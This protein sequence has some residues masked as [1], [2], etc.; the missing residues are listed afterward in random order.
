V[1]KE[2]FDTK[3]FGH[4]Y[5]PSE[6][7]RFLIDLADPRP[8]EKVV[9][10]G[11]NPEVIQ[12]AV[13]TKMGSRAQQISSRPKPEELEN[14]EA[15]Y[16]VV[17]CAPTFG[18]SLNTETGEP[19]EE[20]WLKWGIGHLSPN[21]RL[22]II[23]PTGLLSNYS[24]QP[25]R[26]FLL[27]ESC[28][29]AVL[30]LPAGW[31]QGTATQASILFITTLEGVQEERVV[32]M[33]R[34]GKPETI[35]W[36]DLTSQVLAEAPHLSEESFG[37]VY[38]VPAV[39]LEDSRLDAQYYD[40]KY[41]EIHE[42]DLEKFRAIELADLVVIRS[43][44]R[45]SKED[46]SSYGIPF[47]QV[48]N[49]VSNGGLNLEN[50]KRIKPGV[51]RDSRG[52]SQPGE[53]LMT[54]AGTVGKVAFLGSQAPADGVCIDTSLRR[55]HA[56]DQNRVLPEYL[57]LYLRSRHAQLHIERSLSGSVIR[58]L[59]NP[60]LGKMIVYL[61][62]I[63]DQHEIVS[64]FYKLVEQRDAQLL[65]VFPDIE[66]MQVVTQPPESIQAEGAEQI[67]LPLTMAEPPS[68]LEVVQAEFPFPIARAYTSF[69]GMSNQSQSNR[70]KALIDT[71]ETVVYYLYGMV[72]ADQLRRLK[73][74]DADLKSEISYSIAGYSMEKRLKVI[75]HVIKLAKDNPDVNLFVPEL[76]EFEVRVCSEIHN[77]LRNKY[78]H[79]STPPEPWCERAVNRFEPRLE[80]LLQSLTP[81]KD[82]KLMQVT[83]LAVR[84]DRFHHNI[85]SMMG[86]NPLFQSQVEELEN[87]LPADTQHVILIDQDY[88]VLDLYPLFLFYAWESTGMQYHLCFLKQVVGEAPNKRLKVESTHGVG[89]ALTETDLGLDSLLST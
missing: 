14:L 72:V 57:A 15:K 3:Q 20:F 18:L 88:N 77:Q 35:P 46:F 6:V 69:K 5:A 75:F 40:P 22:A 11:L 81:L 25:I 38:V 66:Q 87:P 19:C 27:E 41:T 84:D 37:K 28:L 24:Q 26:Q 65:S 83:G 63:A 44:E 8:D 86:N 78:S 70:L 13:E 82:Y 49:V 50:I 47:I 4:F 76:T 53:I 58:T 34:F 2:L 23:V 31:A 55:L 60:N 85:L 12:S 79:V 45:F 56:F 52:Y 89:E 71:S 61:P 21:G 30:E 9:G 54:I 62:S 16:D 1:K 64:A 32:K 74:A 39:Q 10:V 43:G 42:P 73:I 36:D 80:K 7:I 51:A 17:L 59:S 29:Q 33:F 48:G 67:S 68:L